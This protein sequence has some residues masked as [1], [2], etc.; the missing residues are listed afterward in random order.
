MLILG[1]GFNARKAGQVAAY[2]VIREGGRLNVVKLIKLI[3]LANRHFMSVYDEPM[4][5]DGAV[6]MRLGPV[7]S[8]S[9]EC[10]NSGGA[11]WDDF[12]AGR[13]NHNVDLA[14][15]NINDQDFDELS[16]A[17][18][19]VLESI[20]GEFG[21]MTQWA[22]V[23]YTHDNCP[24]WEDPGDSSAPIPYSRILKFLDK[25]NANELANDILEHKQL[26]RMLS[27]LR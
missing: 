3:Y 26:D 25:P 17:D 20:W 9:Y 24:E 15:A 2:F 22:L 14:R 4:L 1:S 19:E 7:N 18:H 23:K 21:H 10:V 27:R 12:I 8:R 6:S 11:G 16:E 13:D 5:F